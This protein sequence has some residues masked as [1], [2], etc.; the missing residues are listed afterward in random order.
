MTIKV[1][2]KAL[3]TPRWYELDQ[4]LVVGQRQRFWFYIN[5]PL[6][7]VEETFDLVFFNQMTSTANSQIRYA[8]VV[9][10]EHPEFGPLQRVDSDGLDYIFYPVSGN[11]VVVN[12][13]EDPGAVCDDSELRI[14]DWSVTVTLNDVSHPLVEVV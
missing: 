14:K 10:I 4:S 3:W 9:D 6:E 5:P 13:E 1:T 2:Q 12:A 7:R 11:E 8:R